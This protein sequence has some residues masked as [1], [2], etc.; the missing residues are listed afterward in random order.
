MYKNFPGFHLVESI[1]QMGQALKHQAG[2]IKRMTASL[3][4]IAVVTVTL[5]LLPA[6]AF[7]IE[8]L[9]VVQQRII[10]VFAFATLMWI[11]EPVPAWATSIAIMAM[12]LFFASDSGIKWICEPD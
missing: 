11:L 12:L 5:F 3:L 4:L 1:Y 10:A 9:T 8:G 2:R 7:G 6:S